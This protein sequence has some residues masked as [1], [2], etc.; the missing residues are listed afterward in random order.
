MADN[1]T[2]PKWTFLTNHAH[3][4]LSLAKRPDMRMKDLATEVGITERAVQ[5][6]ISELIE[7]GYVESHRDG[8]CN[9]YTLHPELHLRHPIEARHQVADLLT[10]IDPGSQSSP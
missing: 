8:R 2:T 3:I 7:E 5:R 10:L 9:I 6:I 4:L 1:R